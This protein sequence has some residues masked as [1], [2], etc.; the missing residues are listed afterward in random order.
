MGETK[1]R[2]DQQNA[3]SRRRFSFSSKCLMFEND[4]LCSSKIMLTIQAN[5]EI[6]SV[7][8]C[9]GKQLK[10]EICDREFSQPQFS[11]FIF[12]KCAVTTGIT[13][14]SLTC[15]T[16]STFCRFSLSSL[17]FAL[18]RRK[19]S[20]AQAKRKILSKCR[21]CFRPMLAVLGTDS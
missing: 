3:H 2:Q 20:T 11:L 5:R 16:S 19:W 9:R 1:L 10:K 15:R 4:A 6:L 14:L 18:P 12:Y 7:T 17:V 21:L 13:T 8:K